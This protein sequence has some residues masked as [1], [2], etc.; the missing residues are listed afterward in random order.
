MSV[1]HSQ[2]CYSIFFYALLMRV[3]CSA[4]WLPGK[5]CSDVYD[6]MWLPAKPLQLRILET[7]HSGQHDNYKHDSFNHDSFIHDISNIYR[8]GFAADAS[9]RG[10]LA[11]ADIPTHATCL[12]VLY[13]LLW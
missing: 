1:D 4:P 12:H 10:V 2:A 9:A 3:Q 5:F 6:S 11:I 8:P 13:L 7:I